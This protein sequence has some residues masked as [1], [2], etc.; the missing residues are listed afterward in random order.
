MTNP[1]KS[2]SKHERAFKSELLAVTD[3]NWLTSFTPEN[4]EAKISGRA[5]RLYI[6]DAKTGW[7]GAGAMSL[8]NFQKV[9]SWVTSRGTENFTAAGA[10]CA[11]EASEV[12]ATS[13]SPLTASAIKTVAHY[14]AS[15]RTYD[16]ALEAAKSA[17]GHWMCIVYTLND[18][19]RLSRPIFLR[20]GDS[21]RFLDVQ[22]LLGNAVQV[23]NMDTHNQES[24]VGSKIAVGGGTIIHPSFL[25]PSQREQAS[26]GTP[27]PNP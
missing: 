6:V 5:V 1:K 21:N 15:T 17:A 11:K 27:G 3:P 2:T 10:D 26:P 8:E 13:D 7:V 16:I 24:L 14:F 20:D 22:V 4:T 25:M 9:R 19:D 23:M 18:G 12:N